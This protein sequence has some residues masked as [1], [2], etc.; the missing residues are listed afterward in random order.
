[1]IRTRSLK[2]TAWQAIRNQA[3]ELCDLATHIQQNPELGYAEEKASGWLC[4]ML[5]RHGFHVT[6]PYGGL[7]TAFLAR[8]GMT[9]PTIAFLAEYDALPNVGHG[10][11]HNL[12][13]AAAVGAA[14]GVATII[15]ETGGSVCVVGT[16]AEE[17]FDQAEGKVKLL[18]AGAFDGID[19]ALMLH[20]YYDNQL[21]GGDLGFVAFDLIFHGRPA[22]AAADPW[23]GANALDGLLA[24]F[25]N[26]NAL[27]QQLRPEVRIHGII[28]DGGQA[29]NIIPERAAARF[30]VRAPDPHLL[31][32][33]YARV[34][35]CVRAGAIASGTTVDIL[36]T[37]TVFN[38]RL[39]AT[40]NR[41]I[42]E[43]FS[44]LGH[45]LESAPLQMNGSSDFGNVSQQLPAASLMI[46]THPA[47]IPWHS[48]QVA[49][50]SVTEM[51]FQGMLDGACVLAGAAID[52]LAEPAKLS[53]AREDFASVQR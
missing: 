53:Q 3:R 52:L 36:H 6:K 11:G 24:A 30:M 17:F 41:L 40:L 29:P 50:N 48:V 26:I 33:V 44:A 27:R 7:P 2:Q 16:P 18:E 31:E 28:T 34:Q 4:E 42:A 21:L 5:A 19:I 20:P 10:C 49:E 46:K 12:I 23:N 35:E 1:M 37:T 51:A 8:R 9:Q 43:N 32:Q 45:P 39:N 14:I 38:T 22:H 25:F 15:A 13:G 47:G